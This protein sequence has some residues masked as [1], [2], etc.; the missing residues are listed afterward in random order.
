M[1]HRLPPAA[2]L[3]ALVSLCVGLWLAPASAETSGSICDLTTSQ[4]IVAVGDVHGAYAPFVRIL[5]AAGLIDEDRRWIGGAAVLVQTGDIVDRGPDS[6]LTL[7]LLRRLEGEAAAAGG[8]VLA[9]LGNHEVLWMYGDTRYASAEEYEAFRSDQSEAIRE[10]QY[11]A[12]VGTM[13]QRSAAAGQRFDEPAFRQQFLSETPLGAVELRMAFA[14]TGEYG[15]WLLEHDTIVKVNG[16]VFLHGGVSPEVASRGCE[17]INDTVRREIRRRDTDPDTLALSPDG[18]LWY[19]DLM[20][21]QER[22]FR[23][24]ID[25]ILRTLDA[26]AIV[27]GHTTSAQ[28]VI[29]TRFDMRA[30]EIDTGMVA[31]GFYPGGQA[32]ALEIQGNT[33]TAIYED[34]RQLIGELPPLVTSPVAAR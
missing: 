12:L 25:E 8:R 30:I 13:L 22:T 11:Q 10:R 4:R 31:G 33:M 26:R 17:K 16:I 21:E 32:S 5:R 34:G 3:V 14:P 27:V 9:L 23:P 19:R 28:G 20:L 7:D 6:R 24:K 15:R 29:L 18:P 1:D 2:R